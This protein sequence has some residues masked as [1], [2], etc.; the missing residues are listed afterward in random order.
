LPTPGGPVSNQARFIDCAREHCLLTSELWPSPW[1][2]F[3]WP[4]VLPGKL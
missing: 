4:D 1:F 3:P 2:S